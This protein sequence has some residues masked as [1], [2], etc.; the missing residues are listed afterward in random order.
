MVIGPVVGGDGEDEGRLPAG[1]DR[2]GRSLRRPRGR[3]C[4]AESSST[5]GE[6][7]L[8]AS[9]GAASRS[10]GTAIADSGE[11]GAAQGRRRRR[12]RPASPEPGRE[13]PI[14]PALMRGPS[15]ASSAG[16][17]AQ[18][19]STA[20]AV[21]TA[22]AVA[23]ETSR[24]PGWRKAERKIE[25]KRVEPAMAVVRPAL[26]RVRRPPR[27]RRTPGGE[28]LAEAGDD[29]Q[30]VVDAERQAH[31]RADDEGERVDRH[32]RGEEDEDAAAGEDGH[33]A[34][35]ERDRRGEHRAE[36]ERGGR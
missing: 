28:L 18:A 29:Q 6:P 9:A 22:R 1:A 10:S 27:L 32:E 11:G 20:I 3:G 12:R 16:R 21:T 25:T 2:L 17:A 34:E 8:K 33:R 24:V 23:S 5:P 31:H 14:C 15:R 13:R 26:R 7:V 36:D 19:I 35:D 4:E 30:R